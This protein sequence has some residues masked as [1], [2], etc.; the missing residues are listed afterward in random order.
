MIFRM[1]SA[2]FHTL[3]VILRNRRCLMAF[4]PAGFAY[5][6][7]DRTSGSLLLADTCVM[8]LFYKLTNNHYFMKRHYFFLAASLL[9]ISCGS[10]QAKTLIPKQLPSAEAM[11]P[12]GTHTPRYS[13]RNPDFEDGMRML[14][15]V[16]PQATTAAFAVFPSDSSKVELFMPEETVVLENVSAPTAPQCGM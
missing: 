16:D 8:Q 7:V 5:I 15:A 10:K 14:S 3:F 1:R 4:C 6:C 11:R 2:P 12:W 13:T 9:L